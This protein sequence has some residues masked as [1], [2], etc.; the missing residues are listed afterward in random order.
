MRLPF[1]RRLAAFLVTIRAKILMAFLAMS[2]LTCGCGY[3]ALHGIRTAGD[4]VTETFDK[5]LMS[6][7]YARAAAADFTGMEAASA[8]RRA[9]SDPQQQQALAAR[10]LDL[11]QTLDDDLSVASERAQSSQAT[12]AAHAVR[13]AVTDWQAAAQQEDW[14]ALGQAADAVNGQIDLL[15]NFTA[16]DGF[17]YRQR[18]LEQIAQEQR[19]NIAAT[20]GALL[21]AALITSMLARRIMG[22]VAA[23][24][25]AAARIAW[26]QLDTNIPTG[27][28]R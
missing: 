6:I 10:L 15:I 21:A 9:T 4:L 18:A 26:G 1:S 11:A 19:L 22:P 24:S 14:V 5:S 17:A 20:L 25:I 12:R 23:A 27:W 3:Y 8:R 2:A 16:G 7:N 28:Q 13:H